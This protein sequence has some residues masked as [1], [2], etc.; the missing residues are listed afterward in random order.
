MRNVRRIGSRVALCVGFALAGGGAPPPVGAA[1]HPGDRPVEVSIWLDRGPEARLHT[2]DRVRVYYRLSVDAYVA[3]FRVEPNGSAHM[4][5]PRHPGLQSIVTGRRAYRL[6]PDGEAAWQ[7]SE[8]PGRGAFVV[9]ASTRPLDLSGVRLVPGVGWRWKGPAETPA[10]PEP[11]I[12]ALLSS[13]LSDPRARWGGAYTAY[14]VVEGTKESSFLLR[15]LRPLDRA[16][17]ARPLLRR[18]DAGHSPSTGAG[19]R[20]APPHTVRIPVRS[21][22]PDTVARP[23]TRARP[24]VRP[25]GR[26]DR[27][28]PPGSR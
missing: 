24:H 16:G 21:V 22:P 20:W 10:G 27:R 1:Q 12:E 3:V 7:V 19:G 15:Y 2:G 23:R 28:Q 26:V 25:P 11:T 17:R 5:H 6:L 14:H 13:L 8:V 18:R 4:V 9:A